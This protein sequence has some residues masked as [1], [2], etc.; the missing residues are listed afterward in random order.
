[1]FQLTDRKGY[2]DRLQTHGLGKR[3]PKAWWTELGH[4]M[5]E[6][7]LLA[8]EIAR[9]GGFSYQRFMVGAA[10][11]QHLLHHRAVPV[12][13]LMNLQVAREAAAGGAH[14]SRA[15]GM[16]S[17]TVPGICSL[18][19]SKAFRIQLQFSPP[20]SSAVK[21][22]AAATMSKK[23][24]NG[25]AVQRQRTST[26]S[27]ALAAFKSGHHLDDSIGA[28]SAAHSQGGA[29][30]TQCSSL[31]DSETIAQLECRLRQTR[32]DLGEAMNLRPYK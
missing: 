18:E 1:M 4:A 11:K 10:G 27:S 26:A 28:L 6:E 19:A 8:T 2:P 30:S 12:S 25:A 21:V 23:V 14:A 29:D 32:G 17:A 16:T 3:H 7:G 15:A 24:G 20:F 31:Y 22:A 9:G 5:V 13:S